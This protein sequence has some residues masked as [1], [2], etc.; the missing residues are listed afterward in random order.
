[1]LS[2]VVPTLGQRPEAFERLL[3]SLQE[4]TNTSFE[5]IVVSQDNHEVVA[6]WIQQTSLQIMHVKISVKGLSKARNHAFPLIKGDMV[7][8]SDDDCWYPPDAVARVTKRM[9]GEADACCF[10]IYDPYLKESYKSYPERSATEVKGRML[11]RKSSLSFFFKTEAIMSIR[12]NEAFGLGGKY[13]SG[14]E[15]LFIKQFIQAGNQL[16][17]FPEIIVYHEKPTQQS[18]LSEAQLMS[19]GP[20]FNE[21]YNVPIG[22]LLLTAL[23]I[24]KGRV[25][26]H[27]AT[28]YV[29]AVKALLESTKKIVH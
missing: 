11:F 18:R 14:E 8:F 7:T 5:L 22:L 12:F 23:F 13:P 19:K 25:I 10:Q 1:M 28:S 27:P 21:M 3:T 24:K 29:K 20:L 17:Y 15:N 4:Q 6:A 2:I 9:Q 26:R 16:S